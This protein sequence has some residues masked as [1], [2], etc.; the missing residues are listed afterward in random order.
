MQVPYI[1]M[2]RSLFLH[3]KFWLLRRLATFLKFVA[4]FLL[5]VG[6]LVAFW[7]IATLVVQRDLTTFVKNFV[8]G[9][10]PIAV[11]FVY[12]LFTSEWIQVMLDIEENTRHTTV[13]MRELI[14]R[15]YP[16]QPAPTVNPL[17][18][19]AAPT[20]AASA[21]TAADSRHVPGS[22]SGLAD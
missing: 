22:G 19:A 21:P 12:L 11:A 8:T 13:V 6:L 14:T 15:M 4:W 3:D 2:P 20:P 16:D 5:G 7:L 17:A 18:R 1:Q 10:V 9:V